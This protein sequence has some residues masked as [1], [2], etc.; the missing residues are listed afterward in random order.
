M[1]E[2]PLLILPAP[3]EP[4][5][6]RKKRGGGGK[7][8][9]PSRERQAERLVPR[10][11]ELQRALEARRA[12]LQTEAA[13]IAPEEVVVLETVR[14]VEG[15][16]R[17]VQ[18][19]PGMEWLWE[20]DE[21]DLPADD[22]FFAL[23]D[24]GERRLEKP[25][26]GR[27]FLVFSNQAAL[28]QMLSLWELYQ[29][30]QRLP[31]GLGRWK[32]VFQW[33]RDVRVWGVRDRLLETGVLG[34]W[35]ERAAHGQEVVPCEVELWFRRNPDQRA[36]AK[37]R[38]EKLVQDNQGE[39]VTEAIVEEVRYH[40]LLARLPIGAVR[41]FLEEAGQDAD[42][43]QCE[44][45]QFFRAA[46]QMAAVLPDDERGTEDG[47]EEGDTPPLG[48]PVIALLDGLPLQAHRRLAGRLV[49]D[50]PDDFESLYPPHERRHGTSMASLILHGDLDG[51]EP[52]L[53]RKLYVRPIL[54][55][56]LRD[57]RRTREETVPEDMLV[58]DLVH[59][60][61]RRLFDGDGDEPPAAP[62]VVVINLSIGIRDRLFDTALSPLA[63]LLDWL[64][65]KYKILFM[66]SA[67]NHSHPI[68]LSVARAD[69]GTLTGI[70]LQEQIL[71]AV[72]ADTRRRRL[73]SP[74]E[75][76]NVVTVAAL[77]QD[78]S[79]APPPP[80]WL[81]P[82]TD[83][84]LPSPINA[85][86]MGYRR[87]IKP[88]LLVDGGRIVVQESLT[89]DPLA[90]VNIY[91]RTLP[92]GQRVAAPGRVGGE[93]NAAWH[94]RG[95]SNATALAT[96]AAAHLYEVL[97]AL[98]T[99]PGGET[100]D[101][102]PAPVWLKVLIA[103]GAD[104]GSAAETLERL[105]PGRDASRFREYVTK[106]LG[107]GALKLESVKASTEYRVTALSG[108]R[109]LAD[110]A[111]V[112]QYPLPPSLSG[113][114]GRRRLTVTLGWLTPVN[115]HHQGWRRADLW[116]APPT[117]VIRVNRQQADWQA[118]QRGTLQHEILEGEEASVFVDGDN[119]EVQV[120]CR[121]DAGALDEE[122]AYA[123]AVTLEVAEE[124]GV[125]IYQEIQE[126]VRAR[127]QIQPEP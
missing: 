23:D 74:A 76:V 70:A 6:R 4:A 44:Q 89:A 20:V 101:A 83:G 86:G 118:V 18:R 12:R 71:R 54:R 43:L 5:Q 16:I 51:A 32:S 103:H 98:R 9:G 91:D 90:S 80:S 30:D 67:G 24:A 10:F 124:I 64:A 21:R 116:F 48:E 56:D 97:E 104:W 94:T 78:C 125:P 110:R 31:W 47:N 112:H 8:H 27:L 52:P 35:Q 59:R 13:D 106:L 7:F 123:L 26:Q 38:V 114:A 113:Q 69:F 120:N 107:Y 81:H 75:A 122:V 34:D 46:G 82:F 62:G 88:E 111:H 3:A 65:W 53:S 2:R 92:P 14:S 42:L 58:V 126:R 50:D 117:N 49:V 55:P 108:G 115:P 25:L 77:H 22:D 85:Q 99:D 121:A 61:V 45:I 40:A 84:D 41:D 95:T 11:E 15:F 37:A 1:P 28:R 60:A 79:S 33:L 57:W 19:I 87:A 17:A 102:V 66:V 73:L 105:I 93:V 96:R 72:A 127:I 109:L 63:R 68:E 119:V 36:A 39:L 29:A 100:I